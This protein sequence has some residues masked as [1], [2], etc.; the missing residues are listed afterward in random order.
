MCYVC[1]TA[2]SIQYMNTGHLYFWDPLEIQ[3][4]STFWSI[5]S[6]S[7]IVG[8]L[9]WM[10]ADSS[11]C[12][13]WP[14]CCLLQMLNPVTIRHHVRFIVIWDL[15]V[16]HTFYHISLLVFSQCTSHFWLGVCFL[17]WSKWCPHLRLRLHY[18]HLSVHLKGWLN[19]YGCPINVHLHCQA[20]MWFQ[21]PYICYKYQK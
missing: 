6:A 13:L 10:K 7:P 19:T 14:H 11:S 9:C 5:L 16:R 12:L 4:F 17:L 21:W 2:R 20:F 1:C 8:L 18:L 15:Y 3:C